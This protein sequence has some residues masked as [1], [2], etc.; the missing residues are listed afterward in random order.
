MI[1]L[2]REEDGLWTKQYEGLFCV[3]NSNG[4][5]LS[6]KVTKSLRCLSLC[7]NGF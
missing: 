4:D 2:F 7:N 1:G 3:L 5:V 6:W